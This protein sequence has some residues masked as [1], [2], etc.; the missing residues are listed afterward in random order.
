MLE[1]L[2][3]QCPDKN[4]ISDFTPPVCLDGWF[5]IRIFMYR[6]YFITMVPACKTGFQIQ[7]RHL[8]TVDRQ[9]H[10]NLQHIYSFKAIPL[11]ILAQRKHKPE[12][13]TDQSERS[14]YVRLVRVFRRMNAKLFRLTAVTAFP[15]TFNLL[16]CLQ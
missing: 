12:R 6:I 15:V 13:F 9:F 14:G 1:F 2:I 7:H 16:F 10:R 11:F 8:L 4:H 3:R 5:N